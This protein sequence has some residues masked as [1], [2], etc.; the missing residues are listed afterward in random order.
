M[1]THIIWSGKTHSNYGFAI[2]TARDKHS[3]TSKQTNPQKCHRSYTLLHLQNPDYSI[4]L[5]WPQVVVLNYRFYKLLLDFKFRIQVHIHNSSPSER[6]SDVY[7]LPT[8][9]RQRAAQAT[10]IAPRWQTLWR[11]HG[12][13]VGTLARIFGPRIWRGRR[14]PLKTKAWL[15]TGALSWIMLQT[16]Q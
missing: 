3:F 1:F 9:R 4:H 13:F 11:Q 8:P 14:T 15:Y 7:I 16:L 12:P 5:V 2:W 10:T 6:I